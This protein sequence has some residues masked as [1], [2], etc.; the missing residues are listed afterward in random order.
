MLKKYNFSTMFKIWYVSV[1]DKQLVIQLLV[2][3]LKYYNRFIYI[4]SDLFK[5]TT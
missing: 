5:Q 1:C 4:M 2:K 3:N